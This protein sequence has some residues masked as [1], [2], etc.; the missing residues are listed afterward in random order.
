MTTLLLIRHGTTATTGVRLGGRTATPLNERGRAQ[1]RAAGRR[2]A[3]LAPAAV[4]SSP[5]ARA[6]ETAELVAGELGLDVGVVDGLAEVDY[7]RWT[8]RPIARVARTARWR[9]VQA[10]P[11]RVTFPGGE[12]LGGM[13]ARAVEEV[14]RLVAAHRGACVAAVSHADVIKAVIAFY[15]GVP[16]DLFARLDVATGSVSVLR[17]PA[18]ARPV[19]VRLND[20]GPLGGGERTGTGHG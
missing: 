6:Q 5:V 20:D 18:G 8:D 14:E 11:S 1:A 13:Q 17:L 2:I 3:P 10:T 9:V 4:V 12:R 7:G 16:L 19:L 15:L